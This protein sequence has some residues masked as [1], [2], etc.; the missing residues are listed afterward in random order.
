MFSPNLLFLL[1]YRRFAQWCSYHGFKIPIALG[2]CNYLYADKSSSVTSL[3]TPAQQQ[4]SLTA[5][6]KS[7]MFITN[8][9][10][11]TMEK[12]RDEP[13]SS[14]NSILSYFLFRTGI[15]SVQ[16]YSVSLVLL[17]LSLLLNAT[18]VGVVQVL[19][20]PLGRT[21]HI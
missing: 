14:P 1:R 2:R 7:C 21:I 11:H 18:L 12:H 20:T 9:D 5:I 3:P 10:R 19:F 13:S 6:R 4:S 15:Q 8:S 17:V 16:S